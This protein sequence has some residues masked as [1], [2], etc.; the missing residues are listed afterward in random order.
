[1]GE[2]FSA[3]MFPSVP[4][5]RHV[6]QSYFGQVSNLL[7]FIAFYFLQHGWNSSPQS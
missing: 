4:C 6:Q 7:F 3:L 2:L 5:Q 1:M